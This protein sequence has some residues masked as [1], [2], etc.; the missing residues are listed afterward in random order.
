[1]KNLALYVVLLVF[2][3]G[4]FQF[5]D[6]VTMEN[7]TG[8]LIF[9]SEYTNYAWGYQHGGWLMDGTGKVK[10]FQKGA[11]WVFP[12]SLGYLSEA[13][14]QKNLSVCD[15]VLTQINSAE[16]YKYSVKALSCI[17]GQLTTPKNTMADAG[18]HVYAFYFY[19]TSS[20]KYKQVILNTTGDWSQENL[21]SQSKEIVDWMMKL[22]K[23]L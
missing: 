2:L 8:S 11:S 19:E 12:D 9:Q 15:S 21:A 14:M 3:A 5:N 23:T 10:R 6:S 16:L 13:D 22:S 18:E 17:D 20:K 7:S 1:M 4:C